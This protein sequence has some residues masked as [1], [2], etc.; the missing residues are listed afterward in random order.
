MDLRDGKGLPE[1]QKR[2]LPAEVGQ[3]GTH[4]L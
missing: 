1:Q 3:P 2:I 4:G